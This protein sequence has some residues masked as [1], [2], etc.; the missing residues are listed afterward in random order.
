LSYMKLASVAARSGLN[1]SRED[2][3]VVRDYYKEIE[4]MPLFGPSLHS[5]LYDDGLV[6]LQI[7]GELPK[8]D[9]ER[10]GEVLEEEV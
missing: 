3:A 7:T 8:P 1:N 4:N 6:L 10:Y 2:L 9:A 5:H